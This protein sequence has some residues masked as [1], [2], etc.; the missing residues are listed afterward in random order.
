MTHPKVTEIRVTVKMEV[1]I[2]NWQVKLKGL[3]HRS[4]FNISR[5]RCKSWTY[6][7][8]QKRIMKPFAFAK[9]QNFC[10]FTKEYRE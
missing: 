2:T 8:S 1:N 9:S 4:Y 3:G 5:M 6:T 10:V 7:H